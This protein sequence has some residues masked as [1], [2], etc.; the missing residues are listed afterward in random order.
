MSAKNSINPFEQRFRQVHLDFHTSEYITEIGAQFDPD[1]FAEALKKARVNSINCFGRCHHGYIYYDSQKFPERR[2]PHLSRNLLVEQIEACHRRDIRVPIYLTLQIDHFTARQHPEWRLINP[3]G[4]PYDGLM[5]TPSFWKLLCLNTPYVDFLKEHVAELFDLMP[6]DGIWLDIIQARDC[7]CQYCW[8]DM[9]KQGLDPRK[10][11]DRHRFADHMVKEFMFDM[12]AHIRKF[13]QDCVIYYNGGHIWPFHQR[14][15]Q[16][17]THFELESLS[18]TDYWPYPYFQTTARYARNLGKDIVGMTGK[19]HTSWGDFH[20]YKSQPALEFDCFQSLAITGRCSIGD[21]LHPSGKIDQAT[22]ELVGAVYSQVEA[23]EPWCRGAK[24]VSEIG[25]LS[26]EEYEYVKF[27]HH[28]HSL[29]GA[30]RMLLETGQQFDVLDCSMDFEKYKLLVLP[31][32]YPITDIAKTKL[33]KFLANGGKLI[34]SFEAGMDSDKTDFQLE[35]LGVRKASDGPVTEDGSLA[36]GLNTLTNAYVEYIIP[37]GEIGTGLKPTEYVMYTRGMDIAC[38]ADTKVLAYNTRSYFDRQYK[39]FCSHRQTPSSGA[40]GSPAI[41]Q[42]GN[43]IYFSHPI[44]TMHY[45][46][47]PWWGK[48]MFL[49]AVQMLMGESLVASNAPST[50]I[51]TLNEQA[52]ENRQVLH[53]LHYVPERRGQEFDVI[54]DIIPLHDISVSVRTLQVVRQVQ[55]VPQQE[56]LGFTYED[57]KVK[58]VIPRV[59]GHQMIEISFGQP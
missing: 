10:T 31:D 53:I 49:N 58:F 23:K 42:N 57:K 38:L 30:V 34:A 20:S 17:F 32:H 43:V 2:H 11:Q 16:A 48:Q 50:A 22:Y 18:S 41:V 7:S 15:S 27:Q 36:R 45:E 56:T 59:Y 37:T 21:Q 12:T 24:A 1:E 4:M 8:N 5:N 33:E 47:A 51:I 54:E 19:F 35:A 3:D 44:F 55:I 39:H 13:D 26:T 29:T 40:Q 6:V 52:S 25:V 14:A 28:P 9:E 46:K